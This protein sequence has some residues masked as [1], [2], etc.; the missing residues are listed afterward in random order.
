VDQKQLLVVFAKAFT[1]WERRYRETPE[2]FATDMERAALDAKTYGEQAA[3]F[4]YELVA[5]QAP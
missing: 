5:E 2:R 3:A 4:F 1:E